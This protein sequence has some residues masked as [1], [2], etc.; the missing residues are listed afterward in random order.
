MGRAIVR[1]T[2]GG[3]LNRSP[4][5][6][7]PSED[8]QSVRGALGG[9]LNRSPLRNDPSEN[10]RLEA[11]SA[12]V[13]R[14]KS[15]VTTGAFRDAPELL[16]QRQRKAGRPR[17]WLLLAT[18][19]GLWWVVKHTVWLVLVVI[20]AALRADAKKAKRSRSRVSIRYTKGGSSVTH[21][22]SEPGFRTTITTNSKGRTRYTTTSSSA[23]Y[24]STTSTSD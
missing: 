24:S 20:L 17:F 3:L 1:G 10:E 14:R 9:L 21:T 2:L 5:R 18:A 23:G 11:P 7:D 19:R 15:K 4:H 13:R 16:P 8:E 22:R 6:N 12:R